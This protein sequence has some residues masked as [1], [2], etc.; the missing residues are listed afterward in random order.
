[1][2]VVILIWSNLGRWPSSQAFKDFLDNCKLYNR[3]EWEG[4]IKGA[5][6]G[7][8]AFSKETILRRPAF[9]NPATYDFV[10]LLLYASHSRTQFYE[11]SNGKRSSIII[12]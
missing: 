7:G 9:W 8:M 6:Y 5:S 11:I 10:K 2:A 4:S 12:S 1:M 3:L